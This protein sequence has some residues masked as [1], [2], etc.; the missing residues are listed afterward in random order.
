[1]SGDS[2][3]SLTSRVRTY[4]R[5][6]KATERRGSLWGE[7]ARV[8]TVGWIIALPL[9]GGALL[10]HQLDRRLGTGVRWSLAF[11]VLGAALSGYGLWRLVREESAT[12]S[13]DDDARS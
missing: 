2:E 3:R 5:R 1:M 13:E 12:A 11:I 7:V 9:V 8:G 6:R 10:G 4:V